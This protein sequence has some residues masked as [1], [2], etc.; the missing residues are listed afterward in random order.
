M[1]RHMKRIYILLALALGAT[2]GD[3]AVAAPDNVRSEVVV[4][5]A[6][7]FDFADESFDAT[8][9]FLDLTE[10][11]DA[12]D[13]FSNS[14]SVDTDELISFAKQYLGRPYVHGS[15]GPKSFDCSGFTSYVFKNFNISL[16]PSSRMQATQGVSVK[17]S[18]V[19]TGDILVFQGRSSKG[20]GHVAIAIDVDDSGD[21]TFIHAATGGV[22]IDK[23]S[24]TAYYQ[25]RYLGARRVIN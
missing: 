24:T 22:R 11:N 21:I 23:M 17:R 18:E 9:A 13:E 1:R 25:K 4:N 8:T 12:T 19:R 10:G 5:T 3:I 20:V 15:K 16:S 7:L 14:P 6:D 2:A